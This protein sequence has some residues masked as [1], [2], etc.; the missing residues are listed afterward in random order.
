MY[1]LETME[2][3]DVYDAAGKRLADGRIPVGS[4]R[5][6]SLGSSE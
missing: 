4:V 1:D 2:R 3:L 6:Q 5:I